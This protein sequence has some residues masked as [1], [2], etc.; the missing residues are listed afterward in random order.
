MKK[1]AVII[2][3]GYNDRG[4]FAF[5]RFLLQEQIPF[6]IVAVNESDRILFSQYKSNVIHIRKDLRLSLDLF[7]E[8]RS[9]IDLLS[10]IDELFILPST[11]F[12]NRFLLEHL[13]HLKELNYEVPLVSNELYSKIS[14]KYS[15]GVICKENGID[16]PKEFTEVSENTI[17]FVAKP[18]S[19]FVDGKL[20]NEKPVIIRTLE[21]YY[22]FVNTK[23]I[24]NYYFQDFVGGIPYY[25]LYYFD[26][27][28]NYSVY[29]QENLMQQDNGLSVIAAVSSNFH[30][31]QVAE[32]FAKLLIKEK[33]RGLIMI[34][35]KVDNDMVYMIEANPRIWG[36]SQLILDSKMDLFHRFAIDYGLLNKTDINEEEYKV[37]QYYFWSGGILE[38]Q[39]KANQIVFFNF[40]KDNFFSDYN[41]LI[42]ADIYLRKDTMDVFL[43]EKKNNYDE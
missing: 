38:D 40:T 28:G 26:Q 41:H 13:E 31:N 32:K 20:V 12:L 17:P 39:N 23:T 16:I 6:Y 7:K 29:S 22:E 4:V 1:K 10:N 14:D 11:E 21:E 30:Q 2:F 37:G 27:F 24:A 43:L 35:V 34:E 8:I 19:Y 5:C 15:F 33:Y 25:L 3:S 42:R 36:P 9:K 18:K